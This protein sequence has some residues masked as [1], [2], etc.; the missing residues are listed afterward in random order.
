MQINSSLL[1]ALCLGLALVLGTAACQAVVTNGLHEAEALL[2]G[3]Q[4]DSVDGELN[5]LGVY[6]LSGLAGLDESHET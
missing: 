4:L 1:S 2:R 5:H 6:W 3:D